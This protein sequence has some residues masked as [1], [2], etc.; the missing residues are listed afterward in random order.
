[1]EELSLELLIM[2]NKMLECQLD[3]F[4]SIFK[5]QNSSNID[6]TKS[7]NFSNITNT[8]QLIY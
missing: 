5:I 2:K 6:V 1:M 3:H 4:D 7:G 8:N